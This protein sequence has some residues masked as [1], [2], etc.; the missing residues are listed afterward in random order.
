MDEN[1]FKRLEAV[2]AGFDKWKQ[3]STKVGESVSDLIISNSPLIQN[4]IDTNLAS[5]TSGGASMSFSVKVQ[6]GKITTKISFSTRV[7]D[8]REEYY[9][10][11]ENQTEMELSDDER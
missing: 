6:G 8:E 1:S 4:Q 7:K 9:S 5:T 2:N 11:N 3:I 10:S